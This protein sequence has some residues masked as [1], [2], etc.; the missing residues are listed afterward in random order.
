MSR[1]SPVNGARDPPS[2][3]W[4]RQVH[5]LD[6]MRFLHRWDQKL[7]SCECES[8]DF[9]VSKRL[10]DLM[11]FCFCFGIAL[12]SFSAFVKD[13]VYVALMT[14][15]GGTERTVTQS[16]EVLCCLT[17]TRQIQRD[18]LKCQ[19]P[20]LNNE[21]KGPQRK[22]QTWPEW[23][24]SLG[25]VSQVIPGTMIY[26]D[27]GATCVVHRPIWV[28]GIPTLINELFKTYLNRRMFLF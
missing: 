13:F 9:P 8:R 23:P 10:Y 15:T 14:A 26:Q 18:E 16:R 24:Q 20:Y 21:L 12:H 27:T 6:Q 4:L 25:R 3:R 22:S 2:E 28:P 7:A 11:G 19:I 5:L 17:G 1:P